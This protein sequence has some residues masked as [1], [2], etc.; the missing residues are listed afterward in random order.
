VTIIVQPD[1][2]LWKAAPVD[3]DP[4]DVTLAPASP[5]GLVAALHRDHYRSL[6]GLAQLVV[7][8]RG[9]AEEVVQEAFVRL[10]ASWRQVRDPERALAYLRSTVL[11]LARS[12]IRR[13]IVA[14]RYVAT[15]G[16][17]AAPAAPA[18]EAAEEAGRLRADT[19][20]VVL[21]AVRALPRRQRECVLLRYYEGLNE[22]DVAA[23]LG[24]STGSVKTHTHRA[25]AALA[26]RL[27]DQR[28]GLR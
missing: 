26:S 11:N 25:M 14:R 12:R 3:A 4:V 24:I 16:S 2:W 21:A 17:D 23:A 15:H 8:G 1:G 19:R 28:D 6:V 5:D 9:E 10:Y 22:H 27:A 7:D 18:D 13:R 20:A